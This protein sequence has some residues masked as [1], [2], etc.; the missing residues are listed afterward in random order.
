MRRG[1]LDG[2]RLYGWISLH[3]WY[4]A[5]GDFLEQ[6]VVVVF[7]VRR[8]LPQGHAAELTR[9]GVQ[10]LNVIDESWQRLNARQKLVVQCVLEVIYLG[11]VDGASDEARMHVLLLLRKSWN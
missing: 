10:R 5:A 2:K 4:Q 9:G 1:V 7:D 8:G 6:P 11:W 3:Q